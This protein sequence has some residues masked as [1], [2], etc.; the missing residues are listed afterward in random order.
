M[1]WR[2]RWRC[3]L[4]PPSQPPSSGCRAAMAAVTM[5]MLM[6][7]AAH[8]TCPWSGHFCRCFLVLESYTP[9][10]DRSHPYCASL[11]QHVQAYWRRLHT[12]PVWNASATV[13]MRA[14]ARIN[15]WPTNFECAVQFAQNGCAEGIDQHTGGSGVRR[16]QSLRG[17]K[18]S[19]S[20]RQQV[21]SHR[22]SMPPAGMT[23]QKF[24]INY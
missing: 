11:L 4:A 12:P 15:L 9:F 8:K 1:E 13:R 20:D 17:I 19:T 14:I 23:Y 3:S 7:R 10:P 16:V 24:I 18:R 2:D 22:E 5:M 6:V 21:Q